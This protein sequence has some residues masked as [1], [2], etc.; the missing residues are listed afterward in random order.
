MKTII[1]VIIF[2]LIFGA[3]IIDS[4]VGD[5]FYRFGVEWKHS[6][7]SHW[8]FWTSFIWFMFIIISGLSDAY[9]ETV[10]EK[11]RVFNSKLC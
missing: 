11:A 2:G 4:Q 9:K 5:Y 6:G 3:V 1:F 8:M 10:K 7:L